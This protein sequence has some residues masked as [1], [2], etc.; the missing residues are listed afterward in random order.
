MV[1]TLRLFVPSS[2]APNTFASLVLP[3]LSPTTGTA[4][5][6]HQ[7]LRSLAPRL[8]PSVPTGAEAITTRPQPWP[9]HEHS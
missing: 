4:C 9:K 3:R 1:T 6:R 5:A 7:S 8:T 2:G